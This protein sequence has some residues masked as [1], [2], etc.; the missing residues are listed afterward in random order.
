ML[1]IVNCLALNGGSTFLLRIAEEASSRNN[2]IGVLILRDNIDNNLRER[3]EKCATIYYL[4]DYCPSF[5]SILK[6]THLNIFYSSWRDVHH[7]VKKYQYRVHIM[8]LFGLLFLSNMNKIKCL[9]SIGIYQQHEFMFGFKSY[10]S[11]Y[12]ISLFRSIPCSAVIFFNKKNQND[13]GGFFHRDY[14]KSKITPIGIKG[15][16][17]LPLKKPKVN[18]VVSIGNLHKFKTYN[19]HMVS[20]IKELRKK[21]IDLIYY[22]YGA[23]SEGMAIKSLI[24][25]LELD[26]VVF[27]MGAVNYSKITEILKDA[28]IFVGSGTVLLEAAN[29]RIPSIIGVESIQCAETSGLVGDIQDYDYNEFDKN[30]NYFKLDKI[31]EKLLI[32]DVYWYEESLKGYEKSLE[33]TVDNTY[34]D[35]VKVFDNSEYFTIEKASIFT[36]ISCVISL[37]ILYFLHVTGLDTKFFYRR[38]G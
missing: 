17:G 28:S 35:F 19:S 13:Y 16:E 10:I 6:K 3:L 1:F 38:N 20:T 33:F 24:N 29:L 23:G 4:W 2:K 11:N 15:N 26:D 27:L 21:E 34:N 9:V 22:I 5:F 8:D 30:K 25:D 37:L 31:V 12:A 7:I 18:K 36:K 32:N 14:S